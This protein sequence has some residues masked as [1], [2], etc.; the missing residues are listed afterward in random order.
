ERDA[1]L[2]IFFPQTAKLDFPGAGVRLGSD[3]SE[4]RRQRPE[5]LPVRGDERPERGHSQPLLRR[6]LVRSEVEEYRSD[7]TGFADRRVGGTRFRRDLKYLIGDSGDRVGRQE[8][9]YGLLRSKLVHGILGYLGVLRDLDVAL[10]LGP[11]IL[12]GVACYQD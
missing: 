9:A 3:P 7:G 10:D 2:A 11:R 4:L 12:G 6:Q 8:C 1:R 5:L